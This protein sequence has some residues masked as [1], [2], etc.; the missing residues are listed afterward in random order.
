MD[1]WNDQQAGTPHTAGETLHELGDFLRWLVVQ[2][3]TSPPLRRSGAA[4]AHTEDDAGD[5]RRPLR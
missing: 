1:F 2:R 5:E 3:P 4:V